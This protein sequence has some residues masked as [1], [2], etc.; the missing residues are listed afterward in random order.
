MNKSL[1]EDNKS[2]LYFLYGDNEILLYL[3]KSV[4][5]RRRVGTHLKF[6]TYQRSVLGC[7]YNFIKIIYVDDPLHM[8]LYETF[9][10]HK[11]KPVYN[12][13]NKLT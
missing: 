12:R 4:N 9:A 13:D 3:G 10:I 7:T 1:N 11:L 6:D 5:L 2:G 8:E